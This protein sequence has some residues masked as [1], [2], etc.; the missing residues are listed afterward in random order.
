MCTKLSSQPT[1]SL[2]RPNTYRYFA[3]NIVQK[4]REVADRPARIGVDLAGI[5][6]GDAWRA[7][8]VG[9]CRMG[10]GM[11]RGVPSPAD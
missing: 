6:R 11:V 8:K 2:C 1:D 5:L 7:L 3:T 9:K 4:R 10:W